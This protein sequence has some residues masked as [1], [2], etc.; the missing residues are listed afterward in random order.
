MFILCGGRA[1]GKAQIMFLR[2]RLRRIA[3]GVTVKAMTHKLAYFIILKVLLTASVLL[4]RRRMLRR[5]RPVAG[6]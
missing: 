4:L 6:A 1:D 5:R 3:G 2:K